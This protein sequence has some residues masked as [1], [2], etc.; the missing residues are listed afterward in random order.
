VRRVEGAD[1]DPGEQR[2][3]GEYAYGQE[4]VGETVPAIARAAA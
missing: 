4:P 1:D 2:E 3:A